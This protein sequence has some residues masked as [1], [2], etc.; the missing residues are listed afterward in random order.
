MK[1]ERIPVI[2]LDEAPMHAIQKRM[3]GFVGDD[4]VRQAGED[5]LP[6]M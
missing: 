4:V 1:C 2:R 6:G 3:R 5:M